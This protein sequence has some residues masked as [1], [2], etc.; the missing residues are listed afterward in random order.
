MT[1]S[2]TV[3]WGAPPG[4]QLDDFG[5]ALMQNP[6]QDNVALVFRSKMD[7]SL[8]FAHSLK[9]WF[10]W[11][12]MRWR[13]ERTGR[14]FDLARNITR[15]INASGKSSVSSAKFVSGVEELL[16]NDRAFARVG[17]E[18]DQ[19]NYL[20]NTPNGTF[21]LR[22]NV[23]RPHDQ[24]DLI[25]LKTAVTPSKDGGQRFKRFMQEVTGG[26]EDLIRF[27]Q[28]SLGACLS[29]AVESHWMLF[30]IGNGRNGKNTLGDLIM[31]ILGNYAR[32]TPA[33]TLMAKT[34]QEHPTELMNYRGIRLATS[35]EVGDGDH[36]NEARINELTGDAMIS[37]RYV[38][39]NFIEF[40]R[41]HKMLVYG[42]HRPQLRSVN[43]AI[44]ARI[45]IV[46]F[47]ESFVD[48]EDPSLP[49]MLKAEAPYVLHWL[50][51][52]HNEWMLAGRKL[53]RSSAVDAESRDYFD[54]QSTIERWID[55][56]TTRLAEDNR[57]VS[58][59]AKSSVLYA[60]YSR[61]K[62]ERGE[63]PVS[64]TRFGETMCRL[65]TR[66]TSAGIRYRGIRLAPFDAEPIGDSGI[67]G[68]T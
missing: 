43:D 54:A 41:T 29:G 17:N 21:D 6:T 64:M 62:K 47:K 15:M 5:T 24:R 3:S 56:R 46:P 66:V 57:K 33:T 30:W 55:E 28:V 25:T 52:G 36:W 67:G 37:A 51:E 1:S 32:K 60:D 48:R 40:P 18:F 9:I 63:G 39:A 38:N 59:L 4:G 8:L 7:G 2:E 13:P 12:G 49:E 68:S 14:V 20:L 11:D 50:L 16:R 22:D 19:D 31:Y 26:D 44:R 65:F 35:S 61:W 53:P 58:D 34:H 45:K 27:H 42:N 10:E 23:L